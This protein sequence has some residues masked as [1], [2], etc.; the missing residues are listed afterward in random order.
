[1]TELPNRLLRDALDD[2]SLTPPSTMCVDVDRLA[3]WADGTLTGAERASIETHAAGC[4]RCLALLAAMTRTA[5]PRPERPWWRAPAVWLPLATVT[6][7]LVIVV[8]LAV[9]EHQSQ[10]PATVASSDALA[11]R[12][13]TSATSP[14]PPAVGATHAAGAPA[15]SS[16]RA[17]SSTSSASRRRESAVDAPPPALGAAPKPAQTAAAPASPSPVAPELA[18]R[19][20]ASPRSPAAQQPATPASPPPATETAAKDAAKNAAKET[21]SLPPA[22]AVAAPPAPAATPAPAAPPSPLRDEIVRVQSGANA[23]AARGMMKTAA[24]P[25]PIVIASP[26][27]Q[28][29]WRIV[30]GAVEHSNDGGGAWQTQALGV[31]TPMRAGAAPDARVCWLA[32]VAGVVL[33]TTDGATWTRIP[34]PEAADLAAIQATDAS[35]AAVTTADGRRFATSDGGASWVRQ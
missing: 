2:T 4:A 27:R 3:A 25:A 21:A 9:I 16:A 33:R 28:S 18:T 23:F 26:D 31:A 7:A 15:Q 22:S 17:V 6:A 5:P 34:F 35:H 8:R 19:G 1:M 24:S 10:M 29:L 12:P 11:N 14:V 20:S 13:S 30:G 32:G